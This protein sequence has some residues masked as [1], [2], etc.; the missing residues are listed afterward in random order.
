MRLVSFEHGK[1][2]RVGLWLAD[3]IVDINQVDSSIPADMTSL[4]EGWAGYR[5]RLEKLAHE[6]AFSK[7]VLISP[8]DIRLL[9]PVPR[10]R[11][12]MAVGLNYR[13]HA[14]ETGAQLPSSPIFFA[15]AASAVVGPYDAIVIPRVT[16]Q[17]DYEAELAV[18]IGRRGK[19]IQ[20]SSALEYVAGYLAFNDVTA[21]DM[22]SHDRQWFR[23]KSCDTFAPMGPS[24]V[25][26]DEV[27]DPQALRIELR[28]NGQ[29][30]QSSSTSQM[31]FPVAY[32]ISFISQAM[33]LEP[34]DVIA[35]GTPAGVGF[36]RKPPVF[37]KPGDVVEVEVEGIG[38]LR[39][40]VVAEDWE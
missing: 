7:E 4:L 33:T 39:N 10:P 5:S 16:D 21:R 13:D 26:V 17:V 9:A 23:G 35:T 29:V 28:L 37:L 11:K 14:A 25:T 1:E 18:V 24:L 40:P 19:H 12:L 22:Q 31:V 3:G 20:E 27:A 38:A 32:L 15:K 36:V 30:M 2:A 6:G 34:G 8:R